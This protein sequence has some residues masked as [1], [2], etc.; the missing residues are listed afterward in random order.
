MLRYKGMNEEADKA[1][2]LIAEMRER[3]YKHGYD[4]EWF[5]RAYD[6]FGQKVGSRENEEGQIFIEPQG[7]CVMAGIGLENGYAIK[8]LDSVREAGNTVWHRPQ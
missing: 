8:A 3:V 4:G 2:A 1:D 7:M 6:A 5:L